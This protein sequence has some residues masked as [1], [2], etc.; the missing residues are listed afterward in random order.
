MKLFFR[1]KIS[2]NE[3]LESLATNL[4]AS[5]DPNRYGSLFIDLIEYIRPYK[6]ASVHYLK[7]LMEALEK[8]KQFARG[9]EK[10]VAYILE[11]RSSESL[12]SDVGILKSGTL[13]SEAWKQFRHKVLPPLRD[14]R[15]LTYLLER[16]FYKKK[17]FKWIKQIPEEVWQ[18]FFELITGEIEKENANISKD[19]KNALTVLSY[20]VTSLGFEDELKNIKSTDEELLTPF[21]QQN[22]AILEFVNLV[23]SPNT[24]EALIM[25]SAEDALKAITECQSILLEIRSG[26][27]IYG[28]DISQSYILLRTGQQLRRMIELITIITPGIYKKRIISNATRVFTIVITSINKQYSLHDLFLKNSELLA[29]QITEHKSASGEH[30][31]TTTKSEYKNFFYASCAGGVIIGFAALFKALLA[32]LDLAPFWQHFWYSVNYAGA[33]VLLFVTGAALAT[34]Q[35][36]MTA[37]AL[38][39]SLDKRK[40]QNLSFESFAITFGKVWRSQFASF[41]GNILITFPTAYLLAV[42]WFQLTGTRLFSGEEA[43]IAHLEAQ[44]PLKS[45]AWM[46]ASITGVFLFTSGIITGY[47][48]NKSIYGKIG[49]RIKNHPKLRNYLKPNTLNKTADYIVK[50]LGGIVGNISLG[51]MLGYADLVGNFFGI[52]F[53][54]RH[55]T[56]STAYY[57]FGVEELNNNLSTYNWVWTSIGVI[58]IGFFN[59]FISFSI[60]FLVAIR[61]RGL[62]LRIVPDA[63]VAVW[64]YFVRFP[65]DFIY[66]PNTPRTRA[67]VFENKGVKKELSYEKQ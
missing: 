3:L 2:K 26:T 47:L 62:N 23:S 27:Q 31:I 46:Y 21:I 33:F 37:S 61:S 6:E 35:P 67:E 18:D 32:K 53:D 25:E 36:T 22:K 24:S 41:A 64:K 4:K 56:I 43:S 12:L 57:G 59:F 51:F 15:S 40:N 11:N 28:T 48:D 39:S 58:G 54:I 45:L 66:P 49:P 13:F 42:A 8:D 50:N 44:Q 29:Y 17:D 16:A 14:K 65:L 5:P 19:I 38:A 10:M 60:A 20:R 63:A 30:Y 52:P 55:I 9:V 34:K 1:K 7:I